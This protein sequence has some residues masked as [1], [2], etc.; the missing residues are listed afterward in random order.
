MTMT[1]DI[2]EPVNI[3]KVLEEF[4]DHTIAELAL[5]IKDLRKELEHEKKAHSFDE[6]QVI[7]AN[8]EI[9]KLTGR[10]NSAATILNGEADICIECEAVK[11]LK[12]PKE[13]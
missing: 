8:E 2:L 10:I 6:R 3:A 7:L 11:E 12:E 1:D 13:D 9:E 5:T 4:S